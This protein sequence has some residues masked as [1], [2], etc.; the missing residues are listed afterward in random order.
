MT[1]KKKKQGT[2]R[3]SEGRKLD[4]VAIVESKT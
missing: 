3:C 4:K 1:V 2:H